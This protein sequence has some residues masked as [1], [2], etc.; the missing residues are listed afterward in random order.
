MTASGD[1][2]VWFG[3]AMGAIIESLVNFA[4]KLL[5]NE[6]RD[7]TTCIERLSEA[8]RLQS[9]TIKMMAEG[10][11]TSVEPV[12]TVERLLGKS[13]L[14]KLKRESVLLCLLMPTDNSMSRFILDMIAPSRV[15]TGRT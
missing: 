7:L 1:A 15:A 11:K 4:E 5:P 14:L 8:V 9:P 13:G 3:K 12:G 2:A 10:P 6:C